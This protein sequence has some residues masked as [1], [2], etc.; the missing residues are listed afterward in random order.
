M[1]CVCA[2]AKRRRRQAVG[3]YKHVPPMRRPYYTK[4]ET[5]TYDKREA[6]VRE[7]RLLMQSRK[8]KR[9]R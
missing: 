2:T 7:K 8:G 9:K 6:R 3:G 5:S 1:G 4:H